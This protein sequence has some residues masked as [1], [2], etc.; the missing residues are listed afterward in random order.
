[1]RDISESD[2]S[3]EYIEKVVTEGE[4]IHGCF[5][6]MD[7]FRNDRYYIYD[8]KLEILKPE[9]YEKYVDRES[10]EDEFNKIYKGF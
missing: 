1:M 5:S 7:I 6:V 4:R 8:G 3:K 10:I 9:E 2:K